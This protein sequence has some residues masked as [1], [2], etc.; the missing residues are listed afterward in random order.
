[1]SHELPVGLLAQFVEH[2]T[3]MAVVMG[4]NPDFFF[5]SGLIFSTAQVVHI[6][7]RITF[8]HVFIRSSNILL[9]YILSRLFI[10]SRVYLE[11]T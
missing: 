8:I 6:T 11:L 1:M 4:S 7:A 5:L 3:R 10:T 2:C 9:S